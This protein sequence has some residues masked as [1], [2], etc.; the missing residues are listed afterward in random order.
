M[1][2]ITGQGHGSQYLS[3]SYR[4][5]GHH[6]SVVRMQIVS[7]ASSAVSGCR[8]VAAQLGSYASTTGQSSQKLAR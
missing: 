4:P 8:T 1:I 5:R 6:K 7:S 3:P 2:I